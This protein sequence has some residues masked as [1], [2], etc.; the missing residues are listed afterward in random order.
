MEQLPSELIVN[1]SKHLSTKDLVNFASTCWNIKNSIDS[2]D[3]V[4][5]FGSK[6]KFLEVTNNYLPV[7]RGPLHL[8][9]LPYVNRVHKLVVS[10]NGQFLGALMTWRIVLYKLTDTKWEEIFNAC[11]KTLFS[12]L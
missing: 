7:W 12:N 10:P 3:G 5:P 4:W 2:Y 9:Q 1:V 6:E 8:F 11:Q